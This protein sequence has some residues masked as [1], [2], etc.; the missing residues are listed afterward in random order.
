MISRK[1]WKENSKSPEKGQSMVEL[2]LTITILM[3]LLAGVVDLGRAFFTYM[4]MRDAAQEG[5]AYGSI[6]PYDVAGIKS[7]VWDNLEQVVS[8]PEKLTED[9][10]VGVGF[11]GPKRCIGYEIEINVDYKEF[12]LTMPFLGWILNSQTIAIHAT[13]K[14]NILKPPCD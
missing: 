11:N 3:I 2:A 10:V 14:D 13:I 6:N 9:I 5:A 8:D 7:R 1:N 12:P 4:A